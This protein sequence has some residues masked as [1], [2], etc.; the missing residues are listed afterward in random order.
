MGPAEATDD[1]GCIVG[2]GVGLLLACKTD[3]TSG[4]ELFR[5]GES[6]LHVEQGRD[7]H[8]RPLDPGVDSGGEFYDLGD[9]RA[10]DAGRG[11]EEVELAVGR[12]LHD[13]GG[14]P[15]RTRPDAPNT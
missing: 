9:V 12:P 5:S 13:L 7:F 11:L 4:I 6:V 14:R 10:A 1:L 8:P 2:A 3:A 15:P